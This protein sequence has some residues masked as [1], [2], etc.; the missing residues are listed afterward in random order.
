MF[1]RCDEPQRG[2]GRDLRRDC[3][4]QSQ[5]SNR[6]MAPPILNERRR[7]ERQ[8]PRCTSAQ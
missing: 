6:Q 8:K 4:G 5:K 1:N 7:D 3:Q 2:Y